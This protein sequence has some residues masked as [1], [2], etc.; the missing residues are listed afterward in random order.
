MSIDELP[1]Q[2]DFDVHVVIKLSA[3]STTGS[4]RRDEATTTCTSLRNRPRLYWGIF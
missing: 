3:D 1:A 4:A 2:L